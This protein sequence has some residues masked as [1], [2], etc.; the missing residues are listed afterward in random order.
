MDRGR[1]KVIRKGRG[2]VFKWISILL[3]LMSYTFWEHIICSHLCMPETYIARYF[4]NVI[5][6]RVGL[7]W[8]K[9]EKL[10][11]LALLFRVIVQL[12][13]KKTKQMLW[14]G[15]KLKTKTPSL[16]HLEDEFW[17]RSLGICGSAST[18]VTEDACISVV[19]HVSVC[20][21]GSFLT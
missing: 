6:R 2:R 18:M 1:W 4:A 12:W 13:N 9:K 3:T 15:R 17:K 21:T 5:S 20:I 19:K 11:L 10:I 7:Q 8:T 14:H 16:H